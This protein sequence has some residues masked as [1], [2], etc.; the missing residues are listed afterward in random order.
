MGGV[1]ATV[2]WIVNS[3][4]WTPAF[5]AFT[6]QCLDVAPERI[7]VVVRSG[8]VR[9]DAPVFSLTRNMCD[10]DCLVG[11][12]DGHV[13]D[14][15][16]PAEAWLRW[17]RDLPAHVDHVRR[18]AVARSWEVADGQAWEPVRA[19]GVRIGEVSEDLLRRLPAETLVTIDYPGTVSGRRG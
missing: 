14:G 11:L 18:L 13:K 17:L 3:A 16:V 7:P 19:R 6:Q 4:A 12:G 1:C 10:C 8:R 2:L 5:E 9:A 15:E